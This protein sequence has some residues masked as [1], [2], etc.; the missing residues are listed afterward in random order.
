MNIHTF[1][2]HYVTCPICQRNNRTQ[3]VKTY[4]GLFTCP[5]CQERLVVCKSGHYVRDPFT[6][7]QI[8]ISSALRRQSRPLARMIRDL[9]LLKGPLVALAVGGVI[10]LTAVVMTQEKTNDNIPL[11]PGTEKVNE[12]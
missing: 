4:R 1:D 5:Y 10:L 7:K 8:M 11:V 9:I 2:N 6:W 12:E 3:P